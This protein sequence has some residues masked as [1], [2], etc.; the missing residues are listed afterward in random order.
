VTRRGRAQSLLRRPGRR[1]LGGATP[2]RP[3]VVRRGLLLLASGLVAAT[4]APHSAADPTAT[5]PAP[6]P[7][8]PAGAA[9]DPYS[10]APATPAPKKTPTPTPAP[11]PVVHHVYSP[12]ATPV[13]VASTP[14][15]TRTYTRPTVTHTR[16]THPKRKARPAMHRHRRHV[17]HKR[18]PAIV[19]VTPRLQSYVVSFVDSLSAT[20]VDPSK[21]DGAGRRRTAGFALAALCAASLSLVLLAARSRRNLVS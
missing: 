3:P 18:K 15:S 4:L 12:P 21:G 10:P 13:H 2:Q 5:T 1:P 6:D 8:P 19:R 7:D 16:V 9:P 11:V 17:Q 20:V 14:S